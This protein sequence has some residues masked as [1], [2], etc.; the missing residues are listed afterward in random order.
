MDIT[1]SIVNWNTRDEID[2]CLASLFAQAGV[3]FEVYVVDN[4]SSDGSAEFIKERYPKVK[5]IENDSNL[6]FA[7]A[8]NQAIHESKGRYV[9]LLNPDTVLPETDT[10]AKLV[11]FADSHPDIGILGPKIENPDGSLQLSARKFPTMG[12]GLF[13]RTPL[14]KLFPNNRFVREY[15]IWDWKHN[16]TRNV[17]WVSGAALVIRREAL[18]DIGPLDP[19][20]FM[21][22]EDVDWGYRAKLHNWKVTYYPM[23]KVVH[24][25]GAAS[26]HAPVRMIYQHHRSMLRFYLKHY[27]RGWNILLAPVVISGLVARTIL[28]MTLTKI[29]LSWEARHGKR[30]DR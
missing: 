8:Q 20:F 4:A 10:L 5:L 26:D 24:Q 9:M 21:Y 6:G 27:A 19:G 12:T 3:E 16:E 15:M 23:T 1:V 14:G 13:R 29:P 7:R 17:D 30:F 2:G 25:I 22:C 28:L 11:S 18:E